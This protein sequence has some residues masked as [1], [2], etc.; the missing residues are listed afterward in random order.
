MLFGN[1]QS[2]ALVTVKDIKGMIEVE[3]QYSPSKKYVKL[4]EIGDPCKYAVWYK[5]EDVSVL[6]YLD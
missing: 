5:S 2:I 4:T 3:I 1:K 6:E